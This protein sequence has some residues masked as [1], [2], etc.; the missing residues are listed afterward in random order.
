MK[1]KTPKAELSA[2]FYLS[3]PLALS[4]A[5]CEVCDSGTGL[6]PRPIATI[7]DNLPPKLGGWSWDGTSPSLLSVMSDTCDVRCLVIS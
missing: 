4:E 6:K 7:L 1:S 5:R 2:L 3:A